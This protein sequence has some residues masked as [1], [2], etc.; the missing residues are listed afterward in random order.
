M[1]MLTG[2]CESAVHQAIKDDEAL[3]GLQRPI[4]VQAIDEKSCLVLKNCVAPGCDSTL[5]VLVAMT[6]EY[7]EQI[8]D[9]RQRAREFSK[10]VDAARAAVH[11]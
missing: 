9:S 4:G 1:C 3:W 6:P 2:V 11:A 7:A 10:M 5:A 8:A